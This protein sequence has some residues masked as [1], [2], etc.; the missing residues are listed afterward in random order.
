MT[1]SLIIAF[2]RFPG[3]CQETPDEE[4]SGLISYTFKVL[5]KSVV[6]NADIDSLKARCIAKINKMSEDD[7]RA[8]YQDFYEHFSANRI[9]T[10]THGF[11]GNMTKLEAITLFKTLDKDK[12]FVLIDALPDTFISNEFRRYLFKNKLVV[13]SL[14]NTD[15]LWGL[16]DKMVIYLKD[17]YL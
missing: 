13:P 15:A 17:K 4:E 16:I 12:I 2:C 1:A 11:H 10:N 3:F 5:A 9:S 7:F 6:V 14:D 8:R